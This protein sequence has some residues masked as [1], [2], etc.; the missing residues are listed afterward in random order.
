MQEFHSKVNFVKL[1]RN[2]ADMYHDDTFDVVLT[3]LV[4]NA[5]D[6]KASKIS[7]SWD[8]ERHILIVKDDGKGMDAVEFAQYHDFAAELKN[9]GGGIG[10]A[11]VGAKISFNIADRVVTETR[12][13]GVVNASDWRW[14][15]D[16]SL[17]WNQIQSNQLKAD[18]TRVEVHFMQG[19]ELPNIDSEYLVDVLKRHY[20]PLF[21]TEYVRAYAAIN[22]YPIP[23]RFM[24]NGT[25]I[26][27]YKLDSLAALEHRVNVQF[28]SG[29][30]NKG[31]WG[32]IGVSRRD[33]PVDGKTYGVL[34]CTHGKVIK[35]DLFG[36]STG[37]LGT[38]LFG[39]VEI[40]ALIEYLTTDKCDLKGG[41]GRSKGLNRVLDPVREELRKF[42]ADQ[43]I[44][45]AQ[46]KRNQLSAKLERELTK[47]VGRLPEL[48]DFDGLLRR[49]RALRK[50]DAGNILSAEVK[51]QNGGEVTERDRDN[52]Q[53]NGHSS[54]GESRQADKEGK[55]RA[56][57]RRS[58][59]HQGP[60][61]AFEEHPS[62]SE[63]AWLDS[64]T[65]VIN[66]GHKAYRNRTTHD[67]A[68]LTY[69]MFAIGVALDKAD[70]VQPEDSTSYVD[71]FISAWGQL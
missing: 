9:R 24:V 7:I 70:L 31:G 29:R 12:N 18:G 8:D 27:Q 5:L 62:R 28:P 17:R 43:G 51:K 44:A 52:N 50:S 3:E 65:V 45:V 33:C 25:P 71:K 69:C 35:P 10:F 23:P 4:A 54:G 30:Q 48:Q 32:A 61:V 60:R 1:V 49:S 21:V 15:S 67:Q 11:G 22:I 57:R 39:I 58:R 16:G 20:L 19:Q 53:E 36:L 40:P 46:K 41:P 68:R 59:K 38:K 47:M 34:L 14:H 63:T 13:G 66:S 6:A 37:A 26:P 55:T 42:L 2:L 64:D 56:K